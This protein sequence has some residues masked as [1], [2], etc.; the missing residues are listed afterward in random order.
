MDEHF[1]LCDGRD[2][3][4]EIMGVESWKQDIPLYKVVL[5]FPDFIEDML[6][7]ATKRFDLVYGK[8]HLG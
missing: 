7:N 6:M 2:L 5:L 3:Y 1:S 8:F 4:E